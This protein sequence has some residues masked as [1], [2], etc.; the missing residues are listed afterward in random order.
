MPIVLIPVTPTRIS[1]DDIRLFIRDYPQNNI[2]LDNVQF[3]HEEIQRA[4]S[5]VVSEWNSLP[6]LTDE[7]VDTIPQ[8]VLMLGTSAWLLM[9]E[10]ILQLRNQ[11]TYEGGGLNIGVD[12]KSGS[13]LQLA[14]A[15]KEEW[16]V[17]ALEVKKFRNI[18]SGFGRIHSGYR[19][20]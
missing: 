19:Y 12:D 14:R 1:E 3:G 13:Y 8:S 18:A 16:K 15:L 6:P 10:S 5:L 2:L 7:T 11:S 17:T 20:T 9:S 4:I